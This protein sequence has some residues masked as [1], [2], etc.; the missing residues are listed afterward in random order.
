MGRLC[1]AGLKVESSFNSCQSSSRERNGCVTL[2]HLSNSIIKD[3]TLGTY[4]LAIYFAAPW[5]G[6]QIK[7]LEYITG[8]RWL[9]FI[10]SLSGHW[11]RDFDIFLCRRLSAFSQNPTGRQ[12]RRASRNHSVVPGRQPPPHLLQA[13]GFPQNRPGF[14]V[15]L[16]LIAAVYGREDAVIPG[17][18]QGVQN[19]ERCFGAAGRSAEGGWQCIEA[20][21]RF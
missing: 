5:G 15:Q 18:C 10:L 9:F 8:I 2:S 17:R 16:C 20:D 4:Y 6:K 12:R 3:C 1:K 14:R 11:C 7:Q 19:E 13:I 21:F